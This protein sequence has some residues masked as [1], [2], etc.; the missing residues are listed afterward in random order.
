MIDPSELIG[1]VRIEQMRMEDLDDVMI[2]EK[3]S[4]ITPWTRGMFIEELGSHHSVCLVA[5]MLDESGSGEKSKII[6]FIC[7]YFILDEIHILNIAVHPS[8][9][10]KGIAGLMMKE[11]IKK[12]YERGSRCIFLEVRV[13]NKAAIRFYEKLG[14]KVIGVRKGYY[15][16]TGEDALIMEKELKGFDNI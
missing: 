9:R 15:A 1:R 16:D 7:S 12:G 8:Y 2:I 13:K 10:R 4:F 14:F 3:A 6:G 11:I 5:K